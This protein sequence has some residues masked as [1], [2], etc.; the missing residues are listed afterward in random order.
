MWDF[1][2]QLRFAKSMSDAFFGMAS[3]AVGA[4]SEVQQKALSA[5]D[6]RPAEQTAAATPLN[7]FGAFDW[8]SA[9]F[10]QAA[11]TTAPSTPTAFAWPAAVY[12][13]LPSWPSFPSYSAQNPWG[14]NPWGQH[15]WSQALDAASGLQQVAANSFAGADMIRSFWP[16][17]AWQ[18]FTWTMY[19][20][21]MTAMMIS[22]GVPHAV[23][24]PAADAGMATM[25]AV[26]CAR[27][28]ASLI[29]AF[30][31]GETANGAT[32]NA[33][34]SGPL[35]AMTLFDFLPWYRPSEVPAAA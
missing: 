26:D 30:F 1:D 14:Q 34:R 31:G 7:A 3:M 17:A 5:L 2:L 25:D 4:A 18:P 15:T 33:R 12:P 27:E 19:K 29:F 9:F 16:S 32:P 6:D 35:G 20:W 23:A 24:S 28:Q 13:G 22:A 10:P 8:W 11:A 21:P